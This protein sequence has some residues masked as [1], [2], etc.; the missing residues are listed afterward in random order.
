NRELREWVVSVEQPVT[1]HDV[2]EFDRERLSGCWK[3]VLG[4]PHHSQANS[5]AGLLKRRSQ[6]ID[7]RRAEPVHY[8]QEVDIGRGTQTILS[9]AAEQNNGAEVVAESTRGG[10]DRLVENA[11]DDLW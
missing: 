2:R 3:L 1:T 11:R 8:D 9:G 10:L 5:G 6:R 7:S 4:E